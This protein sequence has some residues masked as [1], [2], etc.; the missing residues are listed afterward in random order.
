[1]T[2]PLRPPAVTT[3]GMR[4]LLVEDE[5]RLASTLARGL[6]RRGAVVDVALDGAAALRRASAERYSVIVLDR[7]I[8][9]IHGD[10]VC[11]RL[12][13]AGRRQRILMLTAR[14]EIA[15]RIEGLDLGADDYLVKPFALVELDARIRALARRAILSRGDLTLDLDAG[16]ALR[17]GRALKLGPRELAL[18]EALME[19]RGSVVPGDELLELVWDSGTAS[20]NTVRVAVKRLRAKLGE[21][22]VI[23]TVAGVGYRL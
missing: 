11:R 1:M 18:L 20:L 17:G 8:P 16:T 3:V 21:P 12:R 22:S 15:D 7:N 5:R 19:A 4:V 13:A 23:E 14:G 10:T 2:R 9:E 6:R